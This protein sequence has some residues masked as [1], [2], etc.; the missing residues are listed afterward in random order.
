M[1]KKI[2]FILIF[3]FIA[4]VCFSDDPIQG[5]T[6][7]GQRLPV[8]VDANGKLII[9]ADILIPTTVEAGSTIEVEVL[10]TGSFWFTF[11][12]LTSEALIT[13]EASPDSLVW[14]KEFSEVVRGN[15]DLSNR[16]SFTELSGFPDYKYIKY[17]FTDL[18]GTFEVAFRGR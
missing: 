17:S 6:E 11:D 2:L 3:L 7:S 12:L 16:V 15:P 10:K 8:R 1:F 13:I 4:S 18:T 9:G 5:R 14:S